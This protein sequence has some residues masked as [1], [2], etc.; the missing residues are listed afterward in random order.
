MATIKCRLLLASGEIADMELDSEFHILPNFR[1]W[2]IANNKASEDIKLGIDTE[3]AWLCLKMMQL[4]RYRYG[5]MDINSYYRT[6]SFNA[7]LPGA[8][9]NSAHLRGWAFDW[10]W[11]YMTDAE[12]KEVTQWWKDL[13]TYYGQVGAIG[14]Y[15]W[16]VHCEIGS[17]VLFGQTEFKVRNYL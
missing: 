10:S 14:Y 11:P 12:R 1:V 9:S 2:E 7:T 4:T 5:R 16:G 6:K 15:S 17:D 13:C 3:R 8:S